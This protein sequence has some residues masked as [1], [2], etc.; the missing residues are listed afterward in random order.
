MEAIIKD[1]NLIV[2]IPLAP[3]GARSKSGK[4]QTIASSY[5]NKVVKID[6]RDITI[7]LNAYIK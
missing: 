6:G 1:G 7:G 4:T 3:E 5:G 2:S